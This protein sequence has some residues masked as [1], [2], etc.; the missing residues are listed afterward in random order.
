MHH[1]RISRGSCR[2]PS[3][4]HFDDLMEFGSKLPRRVAALLA[5][6]SFLVFHFL[7]ITTLPPAAGT[8]LASLGSIGLHSLAFRSTGGGP[9]AASARRPRLPKRGR[10]RRVS[11]KYMLTRIIERR[12]SARLDVT[13]FAQDRNLNAVEIGWPSRLGLHGCIVD[14]SQ[15]IGWQRTFGHGGKIVPEMLQRRGADDDAIIAFGV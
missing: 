4:K 7:A 5:V 2:W 6:G 1:C 3:A 13:H 11:S 9:S 10:S 12:R 8:T 14:R 15:D